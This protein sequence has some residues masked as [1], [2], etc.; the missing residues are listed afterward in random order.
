MRTLVHSIGTLN[1]TI[2]TNHKTSHTTASH[3][4]I[5]PNQPKETKKNTKPYERKRFFPTTIHE[6]S[7]T[8]TITKEHKSKHDQTGSNCPNQEEIEKEGK[9]TLVIYFK[10]FFFYIVIY[11]YILNNTEVGFEEVEATRVLEV[12]PSSFS[13]H[14]ENHQNHNPTQDPDLEKKQN[15]QHQPHP[16]VW[17]T[18]EE[19]LLACAVNRHGF[20]D[21]DTVAMEVQSR[22]TLPHLQ[23]TARHCEQKFHDLSRRF[24]DQCNDAVLPHIQNGAAAGDNSDHVPWLDELRK[25]RVAEL[26]REVQR[27]DVSIL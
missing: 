22:S 20:K 5:P 4:A 27:Y 11:K 7:T 23:A 2:F 15:H 19:L 3:S 10:N 24:A 14:M 21:W 25:R 17:G 1:I 12:K 13:Y 6:L 26:R 9:K 16:Q 18:W 8:I